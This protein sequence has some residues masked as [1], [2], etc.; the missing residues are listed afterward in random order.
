MDMENRLVS[1][2]KFILELRI[3]SRNSSQF[4]IAKN[5]ES[6]GV[7]MNA[8]WHKIYNDLCAVEGDIISF[9]IFG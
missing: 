9:K 7:I 5:V 6:V 2:G 3:T 1:S 8:F 4:I